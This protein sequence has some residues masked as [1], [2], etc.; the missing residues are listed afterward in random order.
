ME[1]VRQ[2]PG[3]TR[4]EETRVTLAGG[5]AQQEQSYKRGAKCRG[6]DCVSRR[7]GE[8]REVGA[9]LHSCGGPCGESGMNSLCSRGQVFGN[10]GRCGVFQWP[11]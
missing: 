4:W 11:S 9:M 6:S 5:T 8:G 7:R 1:E 3:L 10:D 2:G